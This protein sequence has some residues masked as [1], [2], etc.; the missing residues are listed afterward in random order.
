MAQSARH[1]VILAGG[2]GVRLRPYTTCIPKPLVPIGDEM[3]I[4]EIV[5]RQLRSNGFTSVTLAIG[6]LGQLIRAYV[7]DGSQWGMD[8]TFHTEQTPLG[9][10]GPLIE[11]RDE[12]PDEFLVMNGDILTDLNFRS[13]MDRHHETQADITIAT[14][15]RQVTIDFGVLRVT[16]DTVLDFTEKPTI[17][18][19]VSMGIYGFSRR[20]LDEYT[21]GTAMGFDTLILDLLHSGRPPQRFRFDSYWLDIGR[22]DDYDRAQHEFELRRHDLLPLTPTDITGITG[23]GPAQSSGR[24]DLPQLIAP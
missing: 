7:G 21:P 24:E 8:V 12:L 10:M 11:L 9:T 22:P 17:D 3:S 4:L 5:L 20:L 15:D 6:H 2:R 19:A 13:L 14:Y 23:D 18:Y 16:D 1:A